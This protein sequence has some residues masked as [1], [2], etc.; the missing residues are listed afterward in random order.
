[1][2]SQSLL[3]RLIHQKKRKQYFIISS[4]VLE[5]RLFNGDAQ[6]KNIKTDFDNLMK[7]TQVIKKQNSGL[8]DKIA[9]YTADNYN[10]KQENQEMKRKIY[11]LTAKLDS[12]NQEL[13]SLKYEKQ[14]NQNNKSHVNVVPNMK[15][16]DTNEYF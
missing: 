13:L 14:D 6:I 1:M 15:F 4:K 9:E 5:K 12:I 16:V 8:E 11:N 3:E 2:R 10:L 7:Q